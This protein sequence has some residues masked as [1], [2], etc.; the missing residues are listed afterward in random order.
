MV[1]AREEALFKL[2]RLALGT[3]A[4]ASV[5]EGVDWPALVALATEQGVAAIAYD[6]LQKC[7]DADPRL[8]LPLDREFKQVKYD[9]FG[10]VLNVEMQFETHWKA[11]SELGEKFRTA[12]LRTLVLKG[13]AVSECYPEPRHR[14][15]CDFDCFLMGKGAVT[16]RSAYESG[17][18]A[19][20]AE[21]IK[22]R[23]F[24]Y[25]HSSFQFKGTQVENH[26]FLTGWRGSARWKGFELELEQMLEQEGALRPLDLA[27][28]PG[29]VNPVLLVG[30]PMFNALFLTRHAFQHFLIEGGITLRHICDWAMFLRRYRPELD[31]DAFMSV[32]SR[33]GLER[34]AGSMTRL[35]EYVFGVFGPEQPGGV[36]SGPGSLTAADRRL[37]DDTLSYGEH[38]VESGDRFGIALQILRSAWKFRDFSDETR[39][40]CLLRHLRG[41]FFDRTPKLYK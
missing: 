32:C 31:W 9:W 4:E 23:R 39:L 12:G 11:V 26:Q 41:F 28:I 7:Y 22:V 33:Y 37:L 10:A 13:F 15:S 36:G 21:G 35:A 18:L 5:P 2:L 3:E 40:G 1:A 14:Y 8:L 19:M 6:G 24:H 16:D 17:N 34:F 20:E 27:G 25:K 29:G 38:S 30:S